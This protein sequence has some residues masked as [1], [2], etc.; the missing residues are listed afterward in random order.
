MVWWRPSPEKK[1]RYETVH[2]YNLKYCRLII[3]GFVT[4]WQWRCDRRWW[5]CCLQT[6]GP[7][8]T[9]AAK[10]LGSRF[11]FLMTLFSEPTWQWFASSNNFLPLNTWT[12]YLALLSFQPL[13]IAC[14]TG[15]LEA[16]QM[17]LAKPDL[18]SLNWRCEECSSK[19][20]LILSTLKKS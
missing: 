2:W 10:P 18:T 13:H 12:I 17:I 11:D 4:I 6:P 9:S 16:V 8:S 5:R 14:A 1:T 7:T 20:D 3:I 19:D 15:N